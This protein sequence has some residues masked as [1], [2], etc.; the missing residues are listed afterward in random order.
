MKVSSL[1]QIMLPSLKDESDLY[2]FLPLTYLL[3]FNS[4]SE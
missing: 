3:L 4:V 1:A 2:T